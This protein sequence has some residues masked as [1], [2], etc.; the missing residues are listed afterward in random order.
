MFS[1]RE[2]RFNGWVR[3]HYSLLFRAAW[4]LTGSKEQAEELTQDTFELAWRHQDQLREAASVRAWLYKI[5]RREAV[6]H[7][8]S[9][10]D[11]VPWDDSL[12]GRQC[13]DA[14]ETRIDL[15]RALQRLTPAH[16]EIAVLFYV[17]DMDYRELASALE[18]PQGTVMS[19]LAR[20]RAE[21]Q[22][23]MEP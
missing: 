23:L 17:E 9:R 5:L 16:R 14:L 2:R 7:I 22:K 19:R 12:D 15:V 13:R 18:I 3:E 20:A 10:A 1:T 21:L 8:R 4:A 6:R 11:S